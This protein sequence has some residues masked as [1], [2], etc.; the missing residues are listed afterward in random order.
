M[1]GIVGG[2][3]KNINKDIAEK[4]TAVL[5]RRGPDTSGVFF[6]EKSNVFLGHRRLSI[7]D[8]SDAA[9]QPM[10]VESS[11][12]KY[13]ISYNGEVYNYEEIRKELGAG[14]YKF[15]SDSDTEVVLY[16]YI[17]WGDKCV[18]KFHGMFAFAIF[19]E[20]RKEL[21]LF[22]DRFGVKPLY[23]YFDG[24]NFVF[25]SELKAI[26]QFPGFKKD[27]D[28]DALALY[29]QFGF[30]SAPHTIF[31]NTFKLE[32]G[33][34]LKIDAGLNI[35]K[36]KYWRPQSY[37][38]DKKIAKSEKEILGELEEVLRKSFNY[39]MV[40]DVDVGVFLSGGID[41][42]LVAAIL[43]S[44]QSSKKIKTFSIGFD[45][46]KY[47]E[48]D[49]AKGVAKNLGTDHHEHYISSK[50]I[51][52]IIPKYVDVFD[53]PFGDSSGLPTY[54]LSKFTRDSDVKVALSGD[55]GDELFYG[56][57]K[58]EAVRKIN[59]L[60]T[61]L[62]KAAQLSFNALSSN[63]ASRA[64]FGYSNS[65][66]KF[67]KLINVLDGKNLAD[68]FQLAGSYWLNRE[69]RSMLNNKDFNRNN[70]YAT[71]GGSLDVREQMQIWD[72]ENYL[73]D[74]ILVKTDRATMA[75]S[76][77][78]RE[79]YL[80][81]DILEYVSS[82]SCDIKFKEPKYLLKQILFRYLPRELFNRPK[83]GFQPPLEKW[84]KNDLR[85]YINSYLDDNKLKNDNILNADFVGEV[86][87]RY[88]KG[89]YVNPEKLWLLL[90]FQIWRDKWIK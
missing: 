31:K 78:A 90:N 40:A 44:N 70:G 41:S 32:P 1:C 79:P 33:S 19:D 55:G 81:Q 60:P 71:N 46:P 67:D 64:L 72:I 30:I 74:D 25:A 18:E 29:F 8:L 86:M 48:A 14:G 4:M 73:V 26:Y 15:K 9:S 63:I 13:H 76:L 17:E 68:T 28:F 11:G 56:Y 69:I 5:S 75:A 22:R 59:G 49:Y 37:F 35:K 6:D 27:I 39:R 65:R 85:E 50:E 34:I 66:G 61:I 24:T 12:K 84:L 82:I 80:D 83:T 42:S 52:D 51:L 38:N 54:I 77:E 43:S 21:T 16:S 62:K 88:R 53:E 45:D 89:Q 10:T 3:S 57:S 23:Y 47:N 2:I 20:N 58:Y 7:I 36:Q 87:N